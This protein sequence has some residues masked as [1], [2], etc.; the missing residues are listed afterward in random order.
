MYTLTAKDVMMHR[1]YIEILS[2][3][4]AGTGTSDWKQYAAKH[5]AKVKSRVRKGIPDRLRG[6]A[7][8]LL[9]GGRDLLLQNEGAPWPPTQNPLVEMLNQRF[10]Q[11][12]EEELAICR[13]TTTPAC[14]A[15]CQS[16]THPAV[17]WQFKP[18]HIL[19]SEELGLLIC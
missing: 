9:S 17:K 5:A 15:D 2:M 16:N 8:Q 3:R 11:T 14:E 12:L 7:W 18:Q 13:K 1:S 4:C 6:V 10:L 19:L